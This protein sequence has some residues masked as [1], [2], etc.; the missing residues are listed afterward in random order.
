[1]LRKTFLLFAVC[2]VFLLFLPILQEAQSIFLRVDESATR[3]FLRERAADVLL[4]VENSSTNI[5]EQI[6][7]K[8]KIELLAPGGEIK[9]VARRNF[10]FQNGKN[11]INLTLA[12]FAEISQENL[13]FYRLR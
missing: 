4:I 11:E 13:V 3:F 2:T 12:N 10:E 9:S 8:I 1:M 6:T 5:K 7:A